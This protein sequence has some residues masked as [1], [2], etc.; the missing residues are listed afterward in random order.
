MQINDQLLPTLIN[1]ADFDPK[2]IEVDFW[3]EAY[4][5]LAQEKQELA[6]KLEKVEL[7]KQEL[8]GK[9]CKLEQELEELK[10]KLNKLSQ[11]SSEN[12]SLPPSS[13]GY[14]KKSQEFESKVKKK[15]GPK[16]GHSG[17][18][19][20]G[21]ERIDNQI[22][23]NLENCPVCDTRTERVESAPVRRSQIAELVSQPVEVNQYERALYR[24]PNC[25]WSGYA[26]LPPGCREDFSYG[27]LLSSLVGWLGYGG[28]LS[29]A[30]QRYLVETVFGIPLSQ[31]SLAKMHQWFCESLYPS[32]EQWWELIQQP[33]V[34]C[35]DET[36]YRLNGVNYWL[37]VATSPQACVLFLAPTR[38]SAEVKS[39]LGED[40]NGILSSD[41]WSAYSPVPAKAKQ[42]CLAHIE[43]ELKALETSPRGANRQFAQ[44]VF[45]V[46][47]S[48]RQAHRDFHS[49]QLSREQ[50]AEHRVRVEAQLAFVLGHPPAGGWAAD[51]QNLT[52]RFR[53][54]WSDWFT[55]LTYPE[56]KPDNNDAERALRPVVVHRKVSGG[57]RSHWG[58]QL[59]A[60]IFSF[61]ET[62]RLQGKNA[63]E[64]LFNLLAGERSPP[65]TDFSPST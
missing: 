44:Q 18:T 5:K 33:G 45:P 13:D 12:S 59:V 52:N 22:E 8:E 6:V 21:F 42:K 1:A 63:V 47:H 7:E 19:R 30:K 16:Y 14:K 58:G 20:N 24:C 25:G 50:L 4:Q 62:M 39:L 35:V 27:A 36:G 37:W 29:W 17:T 56:V 51:S 49:G 40:F 54:H 23:L 9:V 64:E 55:F 26:N 57:A 65:Q 48:A 53:K 60:M 3:Y 34:R 43:R 61:L 28:H 2:Q 15:R 31:G 32:Y 11:R 10:E 38:S 46:L 41:C